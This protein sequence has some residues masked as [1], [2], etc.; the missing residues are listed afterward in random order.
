MNLARG[1]NGY[2]AMAGQ[3]IRTLWLWCQSALLL[4]KGIH[5]R[6][7][8]APR[9]RAGD[10]AAFGFTTTTFTL[11]KPSW[12]VQVQ[13]RHLRRVQHSEWPED[14]RVS[15]RWPIPSPDNEDGEAAR[16]HP[17]P[18]PAPWPLTLWAPWWRER[19]PCRCSLPHPSMRLPSCLTA[20]PPW[21]EKPRW[22]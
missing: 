3:Y 19:T 20:A 12:W 9:C 14:E 5:A 18:P 2:Q 10:P 6:V 1:S 21:W 11:S 22:L 4:S 16:L 15:R 17:R 7:T 8:T 13:P